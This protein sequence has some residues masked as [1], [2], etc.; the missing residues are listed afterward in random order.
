M[1]ITDVIVMVLVV[2]G[3]AF[4]LLAAIGI[5]RMPDLYTRMQSATKAGT[6]G[7]ACL[8]LAA[9]VHFRVA[10]VAVEALLV[11]ILLFITAPIASHL[12]ARAAYV[13]GV[14]MWSQ[15][16]RDDLR[17]QLHGRSMPSDQHEASRLPQATGP[18]PSTPCNDLTD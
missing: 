18:A 11:I 5:V 1:T 10:L 14:P 8:V 13:I 12:I 17:D 16:E 2:L 15:T 7:V 6:L 4:N 9:A 3:A